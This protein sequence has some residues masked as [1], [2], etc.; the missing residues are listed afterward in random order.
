MAW[1]AERRRT[2]IAREEKGCKDVGKEELRQ[3]ERIKGYKRRG[4]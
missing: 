1:A 3:R 2:W 4:T